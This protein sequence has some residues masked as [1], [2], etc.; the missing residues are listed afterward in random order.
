VRGYRSQAVNTLRGQVVTPEGMRDAVVVLRDG[1][2]EQVAPA[3]GS[4]ADYDFRDA[5][6]VP[7]FIDVHL[8]GLGAWGTF[9]SDELLGMAGMQIRFGTPGFLPPVAALPE[10]R[11]SAF[12]R[13]V[14]LA[15]REAGPRAAE[16]LGAHFEGP[17]INP[18]GKAGMDE[19]YLR[20]VD[21][22][23]CRRYLAAADGCLRLMTLSPELPGSASLVKMLR[24]HG[25]V[26]SIG[27]S[28]A[29]EAEL[30]AAIAAG[31]SHVCHCFNAFQRGGDDPDWPWSG[32]LV[33]AVLDRPA[34]T[35]EIIC[36]LVHVRPEHVRLAVRRLGP[37][38]FVAITD[39]LPGAGLPPAEYDMVDG[40]RFTTAGGAA[41]LVE[42]GTLVGSVL[43]M[44]RAFGNLV[45]YGG[46]APVAAARFTSTNA[47]RVLGRDD[48]GRIA[49]GCRANLAVLDENFECLA[50]LVDGRLVYER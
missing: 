10:E 3:D 23:E 9:G 16:I 14:A 33:E 7:G 35:C 11:Y 37:D 34:L 2:I 44:N 5:L 12:G 29:T 26:A 41:R 36:D 19:A 40:R 4:A 13:N 8:H 46:V 28:R 49:P 30:D 25:V 22:D 15:Q 42:G 24:E 31:L 32:G 48:L 43:T 1:R 21:L 18:E 20:P 39:S 38:R 45:R 27:H 47:A 6:I 50:T 17:F